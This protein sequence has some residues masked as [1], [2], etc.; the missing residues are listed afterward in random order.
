MADIKISNSAQKQRVRVNITAKYESTK[1]LQNQ[2][3][4]TQQSVFTH[5]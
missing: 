3:L 5:K 1:T 2:S 4:R